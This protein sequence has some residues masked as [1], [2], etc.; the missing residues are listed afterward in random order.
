MANVTTTPRSAWGIRFRF[1]M[2]PMVPSNLVILVK[3]PYFSST[4]VVI[5]ASSSPVTSSAVAA[6]GSVPSVTRPRESDG[7]TIT[8]EVCASRFALPDPELVQEPILVVT[9]ID[10]PHGGRDYLPRFPECRQGH[11]LLVGNPHAARVPV[12]GAPAG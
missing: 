1:T 9:E 3:N 8:F 6:I 10:H 11:V 12:V 5:V 4:F 2:P 7:W